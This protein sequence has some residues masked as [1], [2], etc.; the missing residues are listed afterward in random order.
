MKNLKYL[1]M[2]TLLI[3]TGCSKSG[4]I[5]TD[6]ESTQIQPSTNSR[7][8]TSKNIQKDLMNYFDYLRSLKK[9]TYE[10]P[11]DFEGRGV[12]GKMLAEAEKKWREILA[13]NNLTYSEFRKMITK[14]LNK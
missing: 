5:V 7:E 13:E 6:L 8:N 12:Y 2:I 4:V 11:F 14:Q 10:S 9:R 1:L 3:L